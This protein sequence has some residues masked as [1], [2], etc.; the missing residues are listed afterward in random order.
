MSQ[1]K[2]VYLEKAIATCSDVFNNEYFGSLGIPMPKIDILIPDSQYY[3]TGEYYINIGETWQINLNLGL[4][5]TSYREFQEELRVLVRHEIEHYMCCPFDVITH[6]RML[7]SIIETYKKEFSH[8]KIDIIR[9]SSSLANQIADIIVDTKNF[10]KYPEETLKS[11]IS[12]IH[13]GSDVKFSELPRH[14]K[15]LFLTKQLLW[16]KSLKL[17][18]NDRELI[19]EVKNLCVKFEEGEITNKDKFLEKT[20]AYTTTFFKLYK[21]D[22]EEQ[23]IE[24]P[25]IEFGKSLLGQGNNFL[26]QSPDKIKEILEQFATEVS[27]QEFSD[28]LTAAGVGFLSEKEKQKIWFEAQNSEIIQISE[29][30]HNSSNNSYTYPATWKLDDPIEDIDMM[31]TF[32]MSPIIIPGITT[33]KW[34]KSPSF[35]FGNEEGYA[36]L[37]LIVDTS[38]SMGSISNQ[39]DNLHQAVLASYGI[40]KYFESILSNVSLI[41]FSDGKTAFVEWTKNY[42]QIRNGLLTEGGGGTR[43]PIEDIIILKEKSKKKVVTVII[44]D[45]DVS[46]LQQVVDFFIEYLLE[47]NKLFLFLQDDKLIIEKYKKLTDYGARVVKSNMAQEIREA[48]LNE[49]Y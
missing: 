7:K 38:G 30:I 26:F 4:F 39:K 12:W 1:N 23:K 13:K 45:G 44:T 24:D 35:S 21:Q 48:V 18:E 42:D 46:N 41:C 37:L 10:R 20:R 29:K 14:S 47:G 27:Q 40:L 2:N 15:L 19:G 5:P 17:N 49:L 6:F 16:D 8:F 36:D 34:V 11:E 31:L 22:I 3:H 25:Q 43:F 9:L 32:S 33:K 28:I